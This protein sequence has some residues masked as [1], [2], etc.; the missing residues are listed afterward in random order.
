GGRVLL[1]GGLDATRRRPR[2]GAPPWPLSGD[3]GILVVDGSRARPDPRDPAPEHLDR[4][5]LR[6]LCRCGDRSVGVAAR[7]RT[8]AAPGIAANAPPRAGL[9]GG[10]A[11]VRWK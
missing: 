4:A 7:A 3:D 8:T 6:R 11:Q 5:H 9:R 10:R 1:H 2:A